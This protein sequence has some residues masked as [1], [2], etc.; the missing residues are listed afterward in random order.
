MHFLQEITNSS[1]FFIIFFF[2]NNPFSLCQQIFCFA[3]Y[4]MNFLGMFMI[5][6][7]VIPFVLRIMSNKLQRRRAVSSSREIS[8]SLW[9]SMEAQVQNC[10]VLKWSSF[11][12]CL[13][14]C[15][16]SWYHSGA[17][18]CLPCVDA[19]GKAMGMGGMG[20]SVVASPLLEQC[21][22]SGWMWM[23][24]CKGFLLYFSPKFQKELKWSWAD[25]KQELYVAD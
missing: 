22:R 17:Q 4:F 14:S 11:A 21:W 9:I 6:S 18:V 15:A 2:N 16:S 3:N 12:C 25:K 20:C 1:F 24:A 19:E 8:A 23:N 7:S 13:P 10:C 5:C